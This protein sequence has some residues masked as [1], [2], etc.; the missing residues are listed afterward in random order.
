MV[1]STQRLES[2]AQSAAENPAHRSR[3][4]QSCPRGSLGAAIEESKA[5]YTVLAAVAHSYV[6]LLY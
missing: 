5:G 4:S 1:S 2:P 3:C 6:A